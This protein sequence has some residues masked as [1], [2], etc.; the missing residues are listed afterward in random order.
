[1]KGASDFELIEVLE[2]YSRIS[3]VISCLTG[4]TVL[5][6]WLFDI[7][8][9]KSINPAYVSMKANVAVAFILAGI[10]L[11]LFHSPRQ[12]FFNR[13]VFSL[14]ASLIT[15]A[16]IFTLLEYFSSWNFGVD[17]FLFNEPVGA[18]GTYYPGRM[19]FN[20]SLCFLHIGASLFLMRLKSDI[21]IVLYQLLN[22]VVFLIAIIA[23]IGYI[24]D[25]KEF[26]GYV[27][28][29][30]M[31]V[32]SAVVLLIL[33]SGILFAVPDRG[34]MSVISRNDIG[35]YLA[36][37]LL[38]AS[39]A[40]PIII[41]WL[42]LEGERHEF[43]GSSFGVLIVAVIYIILF[44][45]L[46]WE[47][48]WSLNRSDLERRKA[49]EALRK[50][51]RA[52]EQ[53]PASIV[54]TDTD[55]GIEYINPKFVRLTGY[56]LE[57]AMG[58]NPRILK[59]GEKPPE[60]YRQLWDIITAGGE[61]KGEFHN[62]K[63]NGELYWESAVISPITDVHGKITHYIA[64]KEDITERKN[65]EAEREKLIKELQAALTEVKTL[66]G[67]IP[68]CSSCKKIRDD[69][70]YWNILEAYLIKHS[71]AQFTHGICPDCAAKF[72]PE[73]K[74]DKR[75]NSGK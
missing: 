22:V 74:S 43:F 55:G 11:L 39:V 28:L 49:E 53:S 69:K 50:L 2:K 12:S 21:S 47:V 35:S 56:S 51:S 29:T 33:A 45:V 63:K 9:L 18:V 34:L 57:E 1:M 48:A 40:L 15:A 65:A 30:Q 26:Y 16:G 75:E 24:Y 8:L 42:R 5:L 4:L 54:I 27:H 41:G 14:G 61:W 60:E 71:D 38:P 58:K 73:Y 44:L 70:G 68:I 32:H 62:K 23:V 17:E 20:T 59:S 67:L 10:C 36:R 3:G 72:F 64:V 25:I 66:S 37:R 52:V 13:S 6:G 46:V 31:A 19:A 7:P